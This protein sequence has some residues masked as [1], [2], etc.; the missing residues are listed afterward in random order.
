MIQDKAIQITEREG[1]CSVSSNTKWGR[2]IPLIQAIPCHKRI[3]WIDVDEP[4]RWQTGLWMPHPHY[5]E[6]SGGPEQLKFVEYVEIERCERRHMGRLVQCAVLDHS[7]TIRQALERARAAFT[8][9][10]S[11]FLILGYT[12]PA[13]QST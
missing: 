6:S 11:S 1:L 4:T 13:T 12:R 3:K 7:D 8:E 2:V 5:V 9:T 10:D